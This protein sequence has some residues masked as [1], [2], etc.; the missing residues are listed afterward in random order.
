MKIITCASYGASGSSALTDLVAEYS[1]VKR[2]SDYEFRFLHDP[3]G[4]SDL[5]FQLVE[6][7]NRHNAGRALKRF[8]NLSVFNSGTKFHSRYE[9]FFDNKYLSLTKEYVE[10]LTDFKKKEWWFYDLLDRGIE[11]YYIKRIINKLLHFIP[12]GDFRIMKNEEMYYSHPSEQQFLKLTREYVSRLLHAANKEG[13]PFLEVDQIV[14]SQNI[15]RYLRYFSDSIEVYVVDRDPRDIFLLEK[16]YYKNNNKD[17][18]EDFCKKFLYVRNSGNSNLTTSEHIHFI[19]FEDLV[20]N[21][22]KSVKKIEEEIGLNAKDHKNK[23]KYLNP[24]KSVHNTQVWM[25]HPEFANDIAY[26]ESELSEFLYPFDK[27]KNF[28]ICGN[29]IKGKVNRF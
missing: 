23:F 15:D 16:I 24:Q 1:T 26:I 7:H 25:D 11:Y 9:P 6:C 3:D 4:I 29:E 19:H 12:F 10:S 8:W 20:F 22:I 17:T 28:E 27:Y 21:Y 14:A 18:V 2:M 13:K 5:E